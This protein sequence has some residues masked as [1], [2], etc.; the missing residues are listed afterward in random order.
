MQPNHK[1][2]KSDSIIIDSDKVSLITKLRL[3]PQIMVSRFDKK[4]FF[5]TTL[6]FTPN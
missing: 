1:H 4:M 2:D 5:N 3:G 6:G